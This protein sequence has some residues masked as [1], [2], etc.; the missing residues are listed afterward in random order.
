MQ[1]DFDRLLVRF[2]QFGEWRLVWQYARMG[3]LWTGLCALVRCALHGRSFKAVYPV[4]TENVDARLLEQHKDVLENALWKRHEV[5]EVGKSKVLWTCWLQGEDET[6]ALMKACW[7]SWRRHLPE[8]EVRI[9]TMENYEQWAS[10][11]DWLVEKYRK[12]IVPPALFS[13]VLRLDLLVRHGGTWLDGTVLCTGFRTE[14]LQRQLADVEASELCLFRYFQQGRKEAVGLSNWFISAT[15][16][17]AVLAAVRD[18][19]LAYWA[20]YNRTVDYYICHLFLGTLLSQHPDIAA[21][22]PRCN[23]THSVLLSAALSRDFDEAAWQDLTA[24]VSF[25]KLNFRK[26]SEAARNPQSYYHHI[27]KS[28][29]FNSSQTQHIDTNTFNV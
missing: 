7:N 25:H 8:Y 10:L 22:M 4:I 5:A 19:L 28:E 6:P 23:S 15:S 1:R 21:A 3:V 11:P 14:R 12:G 13:N 29:E 26:A 27:M 17:N 18:A 2:R 9:V 20:D 24:H 16:G